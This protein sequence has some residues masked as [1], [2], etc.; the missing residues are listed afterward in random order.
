[1]MLYYYV[2]E[3]ECICMKC[4]QGIEHELHLIM[5]CAYYNDIH[6]NLFGSA[7]EFSGFSDAND[8]DKFI[9]LMSH[10]D[11][12]KQTDEACSLMLGRHK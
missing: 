2:P 9:F 4:N 6:H 1:M 8:C 7:N 10:A 3:E 11:I 12:V 5:H